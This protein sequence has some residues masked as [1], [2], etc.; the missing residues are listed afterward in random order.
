MWSLP[1]L[2]PILDADSLSRRAAGPLDVA[3]AMLAAGAA[4]L[5]WRDK[6]PLTA[7]S[8][9]IAERIAEACAKH[10]A[11]F[12]V[13]DRADLAVLCAAHSRR[14]GLHIGQDDL[15]AAAAR[16]LIGDPAILGLSTHNAQQ[17]REAE[18]SGVPL[19][20]LALGPIFSTYSKEKPDPVVG[21]DGLYQL[22]PLTT[23]PLAAI[24]G[25]TRATARDVLD[26]GADSIAVISDLLPDPCTPIA[27]SRRIEEWLDLV[28]R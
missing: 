19:D 13:N 11:T 10:G 28:H 20:Y 5:Q 8:L 27:I 4:I 7:A 22:R 26:S 12:I 18:A 16:R 14:A 25:I 1:R 17:L 21:C 15:P 2:Y 3:V 6:G 23:R 24:G 9:E